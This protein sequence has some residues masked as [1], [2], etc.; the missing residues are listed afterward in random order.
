MSQKKSNKEALADYIKSL[1]AYIAEV[2]AI[3]LSLGNETADVD[4][5]GENPKVPLPPLP[6]PSNP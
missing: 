2:K 5:T 1:E 3:H 4:D 6:P